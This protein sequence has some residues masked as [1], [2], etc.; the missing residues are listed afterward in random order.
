MDYID[1]RNA[2]ITGCVLSLLTLPPS[3]CLM[4][5]F[6]TKFIPEKQIDVLTKKH[7][8][9]QY[10]SGNRKHSEDAMPKSSKR[11]N[12]QDTKNAL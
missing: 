8:D 1:I 11:I 9:N 2:V 12:R 10:M 6:R 4:K 5:C 3:E 7:N